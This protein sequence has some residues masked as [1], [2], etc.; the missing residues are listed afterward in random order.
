MKDFLERLQNLVIIDATAC[1]LQRPYRTCRDLIKFED[2]CQD[3]LVRALE[4]R[5]GFRGETTAELLGWLQAIAWQL[6]AQLR[7][8]AHGCQRQELPADLVDRIHASA[9][10]DA[11]REAEVAGITRWM[12]G[13]FAVMSA[14]DCDLMQRH[15]WGRESLAAIARELGQSRNNVTQ[16]HGRI[17]RR[18]RAQWQTNAGGGEII[19]E[20][21]VIF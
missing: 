2:Y 17:V 16:H 12:A 18:L 1:V 5:D 15:Y 10:D 7:R 6:A 9:A 13:A 4:H 8:D 3:V 11:D 20:I 14:D 19:L 21:P